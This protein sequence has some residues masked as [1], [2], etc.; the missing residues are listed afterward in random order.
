MGVRSEGQR[1]SAGDRIVKLA[2]LL[3]GLGVSGAW[4]WWRFRFADHERPV[5]PRWLVTNDRREWT[6]GIDAP[7]W[8]FPIN[9]AR[10]EAANWNAQRL[11]KRA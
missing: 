5:S 1:L 4:I 9:K 6:A 10:N 7:C 3:L 8:R 2:L 11:K